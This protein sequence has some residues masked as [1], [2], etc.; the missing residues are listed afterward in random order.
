MDA[1]VTAG[2]IPQPDELL[3][4]YTQGKP[5]A[6]LD[7]GGKPMVQWVL[8]AL[9]GAERVE[10]VVII[11]LTADSGVTCAKPLTFIPNHGSMIENIL[12]GINKVLEINPAARHVL[13]V[14]SDIPG[15]TPEMAD[16]EIET[17]DQ[18]DVD[19]CY[20]V[21]KREVIE[22]RYPGSKR[23]FTKL[24]GL[25]VCG[26]DM[27]VL[28][29]S[30]VSA[31]RAIWEKLVASRKNPLKQAAIIGFDTLLLM[32]LRIITLEAAVKKVTGRLHMT[33]MAVVCPYA[34]VGMDVDKP[35]Q[36][37]MMRADLAKRVKN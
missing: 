29:T 17:T 9:S 35:N 32:L 3:Y 12:N 23:T 21:I 2:G 25:E 15:I 7:I 16:W 26:G 31:D 4:P 20:N 11:G 24:K 33:G 14:S 10:K 6:L 34:E 13:M 30:V 18:T 27:N 1:V 28:R 36:L 5:K 37:E 8:D 19:L 22:T